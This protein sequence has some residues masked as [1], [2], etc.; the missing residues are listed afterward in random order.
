MSDLE[1]TYRDDVR[2]GAGEGVG[3]RRY[4]VGA[5]DMQCNV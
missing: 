4:A 3:G 1:V 2:C 5:G